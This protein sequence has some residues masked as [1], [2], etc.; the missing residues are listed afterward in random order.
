MDYEWNPAKAAA[1]ARKHGVEF[2]D[3]VFALEDEMAVTII[4]PDSEK[5]ERC[6]SLGM[7]AMGRILVTVFTICDNAIR[8]ISSRKASKTERKL[9]EQHI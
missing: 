2:A 5:E 6:I 8:I 3:A 1:N 4:D 9:Y 7:D